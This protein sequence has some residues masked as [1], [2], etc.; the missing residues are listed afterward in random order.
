MKALY[1]TLLALTLGVTPIFAQ[2]EVKEEVNEEVNTEATPPDT[3]RIKIGKKEIIIIGE[4]VE[5]QEEDFEDEFDPADEKPEKEKSEAHWAGLDFGFNVLMNNNMGTDFPNYPYWENDAARS[6]VWN[7]N[8]LEHKFRI[9]REYFGLTTG[10]GFSFNSYAFRDNYTLY[11]NADTVAATIDSLYNYSKNKLKATYL[12]VPLLLEFNTSA[13]AS[14]SF[15]LAAGVVG[16]VRIASKLKRKGEFD[17]KE[18]VQKEKG[19]YGLNSFKLD[20]TA[21]LGYGNW[22]CFASYSLLPMFDKGK[23][24]EVYPINFG[25]TLNF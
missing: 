17:G 25:L 11:A 7:L 2:E 15:Y 6:Q 12:T 8:L 20:A 16:G 3:T 21:R 14:K 1:L 24:A 4:D 18:F 23:T 19:T 5:V 22:G 13:N 9:A 10:L